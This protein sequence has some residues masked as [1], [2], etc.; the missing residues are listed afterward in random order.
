MLALAIT[1][2]LVPTIWALTVLA[3]AAVQSS[4]RRTG[5]VA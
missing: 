1:F 4:E 3:A 5:G 2:V